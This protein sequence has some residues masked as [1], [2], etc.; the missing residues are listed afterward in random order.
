MMRSVARGAECGVRARRARASMDLDASFASVQSAL[1]DDDDGDG[2]D[3]AR[4]V[5]AGAVRDAR[6]D[7]ERDDGDD[8]F[9][10]CARSA[11]RALA[12]TTAEVCVK[13]Q[14]SQNMLAS[15][16]ARREEAVEA[17]MRAGEAV[18][19]ER[20]AR[21]DV[22]RRLRDVEASRDAAHAKSR[23]TIDALREELDKALKSCESAERVSSEE[24]DAAAYAVAEARA[25]AAIAAEDL[26]S[27][28]RDFQRHWEAREVEFE[29]TVCELQQV[30]R[31]LSSRLDEMTRVAVEDADADAERAL[32]L[33]RARQRAITDERAREAIAA[34]SPRSTVASSPHLPSLP[35]AHQQENIQRD[36]STRAECA[37]L[38]RLL[39]DERAERLELASKILDL[40]RGRREMARELLDVHRGDVVTD[41]AIVLARKHRADA[42]RLAHDLSRRVAALER[43]ASRPP[44]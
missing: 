30:V 42:E 21:L 20:L 15:E 13:L 17:A 18:E 39:A 24:L 32:S 7:A 40:T 10:R 22:E 26:E 31:D 6:D 3:G 19:V 44:P 16:R 27:T 9:E 38:E 43:A 35:L 8:A 25:S 23:Q 28:K 5:D 33:E 12:S 4:N 11:S 36:A 1:D 37:K 34:P 2:V 29:T 41:Q 14:E